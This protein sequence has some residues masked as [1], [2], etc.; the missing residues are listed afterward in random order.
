MHFNSIFNSL[1][2]NVSMLL[3]LKLDQ[4][5]WAAARG[6][7]NDEMI[8]LW[9][10]TRYA[11]FPS[12]VFY[13]Y[14]ATHKTFQADAVSCT[15]LLSP[16]LL[17]RKCLF[18]SIAEGCQSECNGGRALAFWKFYGLYCICIEHCVQG[19]HWLYVTCNWQACWDF[20][21]E[22]HLKILGSPPWDRTWDLQRSRQMT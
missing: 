1:C 17:C 14:S 8:R 2:L 22:G 4:L 3:P 9:V 10:H 13:L 15:Q 18:F 5:I 16:A 6:R 20:A 12:G 21:D 19:T 11:Q 7:R